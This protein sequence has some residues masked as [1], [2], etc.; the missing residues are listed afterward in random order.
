MAKRKRQYSQDQLGAMSEEIVG[1]LLQNPRLSRAR[2]ILLYSSLPGEVDTRSLFRMADEGKTLVLPR[3]VDEENMELRLYSSPE[4]L[5]RGAFGILEPTGERL[6]DCEK[7][8][9]AIVPGVAFTPSGLRLGRG[10]GYYDRLLPRLGGAWKIGLCFPFQILIHI[11]ADA[12]DVAM[13][14]I[15]SA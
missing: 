6:D 8:D 10:R 13:N 3:V 5:R 15:C 9:L 4:E 11:P 2:T 7:I 12:N 1:R 14:E